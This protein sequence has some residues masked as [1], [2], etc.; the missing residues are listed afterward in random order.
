MREDWDFPEDVGD[1]LAKD[2]RPCRVFADGIDASV[3]AR[4]GCVGEQC[5]DPS[6]TPGARDA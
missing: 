2:P 6:W 1:E 5:C 4:L 3:C